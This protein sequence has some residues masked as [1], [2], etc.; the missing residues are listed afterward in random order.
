MQRL[1]E[2]VR[3]EEIS[4]AMKGLIVDQHGAE[5][6]LLSFDVVRRLAIGWSLQRFQFE[7]CFCHVRPPADPMLKRRT[8]EEQRIMQ[9][10]GDESPSREEVYRRS[11]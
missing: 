7:C 4:N 5:Q 10:M 8:Y 11:G 2:M 1:E 9:G 3:L 6:R